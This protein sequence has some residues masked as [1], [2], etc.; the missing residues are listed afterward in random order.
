MRKLTLIAGAAALG[1]LLPA[2]VALAETAFAPGYYETTTRFAG[3]PEPEIK[4]ECV[5]AAEARTRTLERFLAETT[6]GKCTYTQRQ[7]G[8]GRFAIAGACTYE[9]VKSTFR[10][11]GA[12]SPTA[13]SLNLVSRTM[14]AGQ[15]IDINLSTSSRRIAAAC[16]ASAR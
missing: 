5:T 10:N 13:F 6:E 14:V 8:G 12:Y 16:P 1:A 3:D 15:P 7:I 4:R 9:G 11:T 2:G